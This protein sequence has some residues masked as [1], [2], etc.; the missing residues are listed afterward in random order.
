[1]YKRFAT[2]II[3]II[4]M[5]VFTAS[6]NVYLSNENNWTI[7]RKEFIANK[8]SLLTH[9]V[10]STERSLRNHIEYYLETED[11]ISAIVKKET[12]WFEDVFFPTMSLHQS[13]RADY[14]L[15]SDE[16]GEFY[17]S[18]DSSLDELVLSS[19]LFGKTMSDK[20]TEHNIT[21][22]GN[23][24]AMVVTA[25]VQLNKSTQTSGLVVM[26]K[27]LDKE[28]LEEYQE[29]LGDDLASYDFIHR[30]DVE[31]LEE[32]IKKTIKVQ[33]E[34]I[35]SVY[36]FEMVF[37]NKQL[38]NVFYT[39]RNQAIYIIFISAASVTVAILLFLF[40][41][42]KRLSE[43]TSV[44]TGIAAGNY[45]RKVTTSRRF[46]LHEMDNLT[47]A[48]N[49]MSDDIQSHISTIDQN[50]LEMVDV[51]INAVEIND[52]YTSSHNIEVGNYAKLIA[53]EIHFGRIDDIVL[54]AKLHDIGK[55]SISGDI[56]NKPGRL[57]DEEYETIKTHPTEGYKIIESIDYFRHI[58]L[59][60]KYHHEH[61]DG[62]GYPEGL[63]AEEIPLIAQIIAV[64]D[65]YDAVTSDRSY[66][67]AL[68]HEE[69]MK[70]IINGSGNLFNPL[71]VEAFMNCLEDF[72]KVNEDSKLRR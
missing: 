32:G 6:F 1:M 38:Y 21:L 57:T 25:P 45:S 30:S 70:V 54:A 49:L 10:N 55:I 17:I 50:Y 59:G 56:L 28:N 36:I 20:E 35:S 33:G 47:K 39:Q 31:P 2:I 26:V 5:G 71:L 43:I 67:K 23:R 14:I 48:I 29:F 19:Y 12:T 7:Y 24:Y 41:V 37:D 51:I 8:Q 61:W 64:A 4:V 65:V 34:I 16:L 68:S 58:K 11:F 15:V 60:V 44:V 3:L 63:K 69:G 46:N 13:N 27:F 62:T 40:V 22:V 18:N 53:E 52:A 42:V 66:R 72:K 9:Y